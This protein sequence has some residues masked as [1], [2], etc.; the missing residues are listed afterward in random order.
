MLNFFKKVFGKAE[1]KKEEVQK[2]NKSAERQ[3]SMPTQP[4]NPF[5]PQS[6]DQDNVEV[7]VF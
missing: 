2:Q 7:D 6:S 1:K 3:R 5:P 4:S